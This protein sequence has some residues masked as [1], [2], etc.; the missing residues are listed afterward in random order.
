[1]E[2]IEIQNLTNA[3]KETVF[4]RAFHKKKNNTIL[5]CKYIA[6]NLFCFVA[7]HSQSHL[8]IKKHILAHT[9]KTHK[10]TKKV[11]KAT[12]K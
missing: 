1:M 4:Q 3:L 6:Y 11:Y 8:Y 10:Y 9:K 5:M 2:S 7:L 12:V